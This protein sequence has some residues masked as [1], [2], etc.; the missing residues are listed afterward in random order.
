M[1]ESTL[2]AQPSTERDDEAGKRVAEANERRS[3][4]RI[5]QRVALTSRP[6]QSGIA[7]A[8]DHGSHWKFLIAFVICEACTTKWLLT[9]LAPET[10]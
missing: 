6:R 10:N 9:K 2:F 3:L 4:H 8:A 5:E 1:K 7:V